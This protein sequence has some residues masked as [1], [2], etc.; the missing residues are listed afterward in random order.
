MEFN[1]IQPKKSTLGATKTGIQ[2]NVQS[3]GSLSN[4]TDIGA[5]DAERQSEGVV[6]V[7]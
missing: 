2:S 1:K 5:T 6:V 4:T 7:D 3:T